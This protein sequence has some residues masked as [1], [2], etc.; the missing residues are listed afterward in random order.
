MRIINLNLLAAVLFAA[1]AAAADLYS[2]E[3]LPPMTEPGGFEA[4]WNF[5]AAVYVWAAGMKGTTGFGDL[6]TV[7]IDASFSD[8]LENLDFAFMAVGEARYDRFGV[9][10]DLIYTKLSA[11]GTGPMGL[12]ASVE[13][14]TIV[15]T[16]MGEYRVVEAGNT[17]VDVM[18][19][20]RVWG[21]M[22]DLNVTGGGGI[23]SGGRDFDRYWVDPMVGA[24][25]RLQGDS[26]WFLTS[27]AMIG[28][29][30]AAS[31]IDWD[32]FGGVG[33]EV[34]DWLS[35]VA[36]YRALGV[37]YDRDGFLFDVTQQGPIIGGVFRF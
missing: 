10:G 19:G 34:K 9:F 32:V 31:D 33:Y 37:D 6:P 18:A 4:R 22:M 8:I 30:G 23:V 21:V 28:G 29:F 26:P 3:P 14:K 17:S 25:A 1:P 13:N 15:G 7:D 20:A 27:W 11:D 12:T 16:L 24:K 35:L 5:S 36:G 2:D